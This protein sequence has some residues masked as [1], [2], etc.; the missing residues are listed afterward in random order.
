VKLI[1]LDRVDQLRQK[2]EG[3]L[4]DVTMEILRVLSSPDI[5]VRRKALT[6]ALELVSSKNVA[7]FIMILQKELSKT[8][9]EQYEKNQEYRSLL[10]HGIHQCAIRHSEV[11]ASV[12]GSLMDFISDLSSVA[13]WLKSRTWC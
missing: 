13:N 5:D 3:V 12:V 7:E 9:Q 2:N 10:I 1:C 11:A 8:T 4:D 6:I